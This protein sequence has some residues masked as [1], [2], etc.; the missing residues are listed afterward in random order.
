MPSSGVLERAARS[1][2]SIHRI[3]VHWVLVWVLAWVLVW[4]LAW[5]MGWVPV[6]PGRTCPATDPTQAARVYRCPPGTHSTPAAA[7]IAL[8]KGPEEIG[9]P[10]RQPSGCTSAARALHDTAPRTAQGLHQNHAGTTP[11]TAHRAIHR[12]TQ[13][14]RKNYA[15]TGWGRIG[16]EL[17]GTRRELRGRAPVGLGSGPGVGQGIR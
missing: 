4:V 9:A 14:L 17:R 13:E 12:G 1:P 2:A 15:R 11:G 6:E 5:V 3:L 10:L 8:R 7:S 16:Q